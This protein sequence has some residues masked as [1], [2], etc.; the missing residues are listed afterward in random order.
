M[1]F[2]FPP[3]VRAGFVDS[4]NPGALTALV[5]FAVF[6]FLINRFRHSLRIQGWCFI[7]GVGIVTGY[8]ALGT[9]DPFLSSKRYDLFL[10]VFYFCAAVVFVVTGA[11]FFRDWIIVKK[12]GGDARLVITPVLFS[13]NSCGCF[14]GKK[15]GEK[16]KLRYKIGCGAVSFCCGGLVAFLESAWPADQYITIMLYQEI[17]GKQASAVFN[18]ILYVV[19]FVLPLFVV[20]SAGQWVSRSQKFRA[21]M[22]SSQ[23][24]VQI[25]ISA[26]FFAYGVVLL[27][28]YF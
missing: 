18:L 22:I 21:K 6:L 23:S 24:K 7:A 25:I 8:I 16:R 13:S 17:L 19:V 26:I 4:A 2:R 20:L 5:L 14:G 15:D 11:L 12:D 1:A 10:D 9:F 3:A 27:M 28:Y